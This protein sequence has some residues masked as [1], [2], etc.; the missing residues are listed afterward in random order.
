MCR[1][2]AHRRHWWLCVALA[3]AL[4]SASCS[5][6]SSPVEVSAVSNSKVSPTTSA[7]PDGTYQADNVIPPEPKLF[8]GETMGRQ[9]PIGSPCTAEDGWQAVSHENDAAFG[10]VVPS[11]DERGI[12]DLPPGIGYCLTPGG[13]YPYGYFT[14]TCTRDSDCPSD[15]VCDMTL[16]RAPCRTDADCNPPTACVLKGVPFCRRPPG[17]PAL[18]FNNASSF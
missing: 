16:C 1:A 2:H 8:P 6:S 10:L 18:E 13:L 9:L 4:L 7:P 17:D 14:M 5:Q 3:S 12:G 11:P 15:A